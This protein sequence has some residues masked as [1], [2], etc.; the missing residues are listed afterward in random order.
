MKH[1]VYER[2][3]ETDRVG[4]GER[5]IYSKPDADKEEMLKRVEA[6][7]EP[8]PGHQALNALVGSWKAEVKCWMEPG[9]APEVSQAT[10]VANWTLNGHF[11]EEKFRGKMMG[12]PFIGRSLIGFDNTKQTYNSVWISDMQTSMF[13]SEGKGESGNKVI[14]LEGKVSCAA[15]GRKDVPM[16]TVYRLIGPDKHVFELFD[17]SRGENTKTMEIIYIRE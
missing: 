16:K 12:K 13:T 6:A 1:D 15:T 7:A 17:G 9:Q 14:K 4:A 8:G 10:A 2:E 5:A 11:L 3:T